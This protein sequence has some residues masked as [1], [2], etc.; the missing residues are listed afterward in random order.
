MKQVF[1]LVVPVLISCVLAIPTWGQNVN[2]VEIHYF[3]TERKSGWQLK[4]GLR[5][6]EGP[7]GTYDGS[8]N[9]D[10]E[11]LG[12]EKRLDRCNGGEIRGNYAYFI[13]DNYPFVPRCLYG[14]ISSD[15]NRNQHR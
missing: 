2:R 15:F 4:K 7:P 10:Y 9:E 11:Y 8:Y 6:G 3:P 13:T 1:I 5:P 14:E 12:G